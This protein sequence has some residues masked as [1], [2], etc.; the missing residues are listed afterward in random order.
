MW[1]NMKKDGGF[2]APAAGVAFGSSGG[3]LQ[4]VQEAGPLRGA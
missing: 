4:A 2:A 3:Y 1:E